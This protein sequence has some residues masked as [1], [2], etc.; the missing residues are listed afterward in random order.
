MLA[1]YLS[2]T[3]YLRSLRLPPHVYCDWSTAVS[4][5]TAEM[6]RFKLR[7]AIHFPSLREIRLHTLL[8][9]ARSSISAILASNTVVP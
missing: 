9:F 5:A 4:L 6:S 8:I 7:P 1:K 2:L 3:L